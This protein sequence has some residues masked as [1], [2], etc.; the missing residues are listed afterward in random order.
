MGKGKSRFADSLHDIGNRAST[1]PAQIDSAYQV[2]G[3][4]VL[5]TALGMYQKMA[6]NDPR[7]MGMC[8]LLNEMVGEAGRIMAEGNSQ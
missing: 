5:E 7:F 1:R 4:I 8:Y 6:V 2:E 3:K